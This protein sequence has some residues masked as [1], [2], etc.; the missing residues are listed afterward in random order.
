MTFFLNGNV[1]ASQ[2]TEL[3]AATFNER[4]NKSHMNQ[5]IKI[6]KADPSGRF[7][8]TLNEM[9]FMTTQLDPYSQSFVEYA[10]KIKEPVLEVGAAYG[11]ATL[12]ALSRGATV[13]CNDIDIRHLKIV[14]QQANKNDLARLK[15]V[16]GAFPKELD[17]PENSFGAILMA[18][19]IHFFDPET[20]QLAMKKAYSWLKP[21][22]K[23]VI[24]ADTPYLKNMADFIPEYERRVKNGDKWPGIMGDPKQF[25]N[26]PHFHDFLHVLDDKVLSRVLSEQ[27]FE[28]E[29]IEMLSRVD[30]PA[31]RQLDGRESVAVIAV[32]PNQ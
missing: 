30:Y 20:L 14:E 5:Q 32:K 19:V 31:D 10:I 4:N 17:F 21:G 7:I 6:P 8:P 29:K 9:G 28:V 2:D 27:G 11:V 12:A 13:Y 18:R 1:F 16:P 15:L 25:T 26:N 23:L 24:I 22:G 3:K